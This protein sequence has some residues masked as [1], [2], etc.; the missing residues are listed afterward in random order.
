MIFLAYQFG[1][2]KL[3]W[4]NSEM[5]QLTNMKTP[6]IVSEKEKFIQL[7]S[8]SDRSSQGGIKVR[9]GVYRGHG[10]QNL[11]R[12]TLFNSLN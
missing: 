12:V 6:I 2:G 1:L 9:K 7:N 8:S 5:E 3:N 11:S 4:H 10:R